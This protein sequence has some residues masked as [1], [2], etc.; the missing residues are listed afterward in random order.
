VIVCHSRRRTDLAA[1]TYNAVQMVTRRFADKLVR[2][3]ST[4][5]LPIL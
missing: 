4:R 5:G 3:Q 1:M 2:D